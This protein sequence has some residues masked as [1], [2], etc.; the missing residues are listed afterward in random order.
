MSNEVPRKYTEDELYEIAAVFYDVEAHRRSPSVFAG[1]RPLYGPNFFE[2]PAATQ[3][4]TVA[5]LKSRIANETLP[6]YLERKKRQV[7]ADVIKP[8]EDELKQRGLL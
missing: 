6:G 2:L 7:G 4:T 8:V 1:T 3:K 5:G